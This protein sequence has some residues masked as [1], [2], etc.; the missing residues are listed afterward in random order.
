LIKGLLVSGAA[1]SLVRSSVP[2]SGGEHLFSHLL[3][4]RESIA[5]RIPVRNPFHSILR[6]AVKPQHIGFSN[7]LKIKSFS[8]N[9]SCIN[10]DFQYSILF[11]TGI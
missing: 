9:G 1:V 6:F 5:G 7:V 3:D 10:F 8:Q 2:A 4:M 11:A